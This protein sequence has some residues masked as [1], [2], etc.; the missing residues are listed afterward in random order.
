MRI[1]RLAPIFAAALLVGTAHAATGTP[2]APT[3]LHGFLLRADEAATTT[4]HRTPSFAWNPVVGAVGYQFQIATSSTFRDNGIVYNTNTLTTPVAAPPIIL[5]W[6]TG[7]PHALYARVRAT[8]ATDVS[9]WSAA[10]GFDVTPPAPPTPLP[11]NPGLLRWTP[12]DGASSYQVW[13]VDVL[14][15]KKETVRTNVLDEREFYTFHQS[16][17]WISKVRWR[18]RASRSNAS[19]GPVNG[20]PATTY[21]AWSPIYSTSNPAPTGGPIKLVQTVSDVVSAGASNSPAHRLMPGFVW[22][23]NQSL[24]GAPA[25]LFRV[26]V[27]TD[28]QC[29]NLVYTS[30]VVGSPA[31]APRP[32]GPLSLPQDPVAIANALGKYLTDGTEVGG[33][34]YD[35]T[36]VSPAEQLAPAAPTLIPPA[37]DGPA[38]PAAPPPASGSSDPSSSSAPPAGAPV[39]AGAPVDLWDTDWPQSGYYWTVIP[40]S[41]SSGSS[42]SS[43][44][45]APGASKGSTLVPVADPS[46]FSVGES[47][48]IGVSPNT[49]TAT[50]TAIGSSLLTISTAL[51]N[52]HSPGDAVTTTNSSG[53]VYQDMELPQDA[54]AA[55][56][57]QRF[58]ISSEPAL[59]T[60]QQPFATGLSSDG[61]LTSAANTPTFYGRP[62]V[63]WTPALGS[64]VYQVQWS[65]TQYP[66]VSQGQ[67]MTTSTSTVLPLAAGTWYYRVRGFDYN[68]PTGVQQMS[69]SNAQKL[70]VSKPTFKIVPSPTT[71]NK[72]KVVPSKPKARTTQIVSLTSVQTAATQN[73]VAPKG[74]SVGDKYFLSDQ[75]LN[76]GAQFGKTAGTAVGSDR[77]TITITGAHTGTVAGV[78]TLPGGTIRFS[79]AVGSNDLVTSLKVTGGTGAFAGAQGTF[80][81]SGTADRFVLSLPGA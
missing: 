19:G 71:G 53:V 65:K 3:G 76:I 26:Y 8:T 54:C 68:L 80:T 31:Y 79:G 4:Y 22:T 60:A 36:A 2:A 29:L 69:W 28:S 49:D 24:S 11:S 81:Q 1:A 15:G 14:G 27:F 48:T 35:G 44:V 17:Q 46:Q 63:A 61:R 33:E 51:G 73:D 37:D 77:V 56:R 52:G 23:G 66:F 78:A 7:S 42:G 9:P 25:E 6:I 59:T 40:V 72:F 10:F 75:L 32:G 20:L 21:G 16:A 57:V 45:V 39:S 74:R 50:I 55:G 41:T 12:V 67:T 13:L 62:L 64:Q 30:A 43:T 58:G 38:T 47:I 18:V 34:M 70:V 5:P